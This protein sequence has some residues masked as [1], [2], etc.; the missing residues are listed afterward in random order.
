MYQDPD[1]GRWGGGGGWPPEP[2][3]LSPPCLWVAAG[4]C[5]EHWGCWGALGELG[6]LGAL[7]VPGTYHLWELDVSEAGNEGLAQP[8]QLLQQALVVLFYQFVLLL[9]RL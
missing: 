9:Y 1:D 2:T 7:G 5:W 4:Q 6:M 8:R 3:L